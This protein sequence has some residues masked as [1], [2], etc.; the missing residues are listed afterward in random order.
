MLV[1]A[2]VPF[3]SIIEIAEEIGWKRLT[4]IFFSRRDAT[5]QGTGAAND[6]KG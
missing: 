5:K 6:S 1:V 4:A 2:F 3:F